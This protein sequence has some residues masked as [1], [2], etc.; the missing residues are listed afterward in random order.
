MIPTC[1]THQKPMRPGRG[2]GQFYCAEFMGVGVPGSNAKGYCQQKV[3]VPA[4]NHVPLP[5]VPM[6]GVAGPVV[7][8][9]VASPQNV[10]LEAASVAAKAAATVHMGRG[11]DPQDVVACAR[12]IYHGLLKPAFLGDVPLPIPVP[13]E[14]DADVPSTIR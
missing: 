2:P 10:R 8:P 14:W 11:S 6:P 4:Q 5:Q 12:A 1:P 13:T 7:A 3:T 9:A